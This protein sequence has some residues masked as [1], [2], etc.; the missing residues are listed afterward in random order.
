MPYDLV[1]LDL[2]GTIL[3]GSFKLDQPLAAACR[4]AIRRG[5]TVTLATGRMPPAARRYWE[6]LGITAPVILYNGALVS[7]PANGRNL[8]AVTLP[9]GLPCEV[10]PIIATVPVHPLFYQNDRL[11]CLQ[12]TP[13][14]IAYCR[15]MG[16][17]AEPISEPESFL[18]SDPFVKCLFTGHDD[19]LRT[20]REK[21]TP[22][23]GGRARLVA[24][25]PG[26]LE[27]LPAG[28]SKGVA[29]RF[30]AGHLGVP[31]ERIIAAGDQENDIEMISEAGMGI[32]IA[33][34]PEEVRAAADRVAP[35]PEQGG[36]LALLSAL[37]PGYFSP[38]STS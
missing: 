1:V 30:L 36:L 34:A 27:L 3:D 9:T 29:L 2:D 7:D 37:C 11:Y 14:V 8:Y 26:H 25:R 20:L 18:K 28:A 38:P 12:L 33:H 16:V 5:L 15:D 6:E 24:S 17:D 21:L 31:L 13:E 10:L 23:V 19:D 32:A 35:P 4:R 22:A